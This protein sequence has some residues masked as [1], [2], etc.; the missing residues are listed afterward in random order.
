MHSLTTSLLCA[1]IALSFLGL[2]FIYLLRKP[3]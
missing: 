2:Y 1:F 3:L